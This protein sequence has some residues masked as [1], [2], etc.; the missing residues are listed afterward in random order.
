MTQRAQSTR[1][2]LSEMAFKHLKY[3]L[4]PYRSVPHLQLAGERDLPPGLTDCQD[5]LRLLQKLRLR[6]D[7]DGAYTATQAK[8]RQSFNKDP[9]AANDEASCAKGMDSWTV[10][11]IPRNEL[12]Q[13]QY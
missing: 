2:Y 11:G 13:G 9:S 1:Q 7:F 3:P 4:I 8:L 5:Q 6:S 12:N 10:Q